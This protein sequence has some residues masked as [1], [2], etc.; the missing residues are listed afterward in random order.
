MSGFTTALRSLVGPEFFDTVKWN[1]QQAQAVT[2]GAHPHILEFRKKLIAKFRKM[3]VPLYAHNM[4]RDAE[5]QNRLYVQGV[6]KAQAGK[7][8]HNFGMAVDIVSSLHHWEISSEA[9]NI[10]GHLG[11]E[12]AIQNGFRLVWGGDWRDP[13]GPG[14]KVGWDPAHWEIANWK[15]LKGEFPWPPPIQARPT[16]LPSSPLARKPP[17]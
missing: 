12:L 8:P 3:N 11:K 14:P 17:S 16:K 10:I 7:S 2:I 6:S 13:D 5:H 1:D 15:N 9:W 4:I